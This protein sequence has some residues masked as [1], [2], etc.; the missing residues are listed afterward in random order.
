[1]SYVFGARL[2]LKIKGGMPFHRTYD[3]KI[4][5]NCRYSLVCVGF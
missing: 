3:A 4:P 1:M 2:E 5:I